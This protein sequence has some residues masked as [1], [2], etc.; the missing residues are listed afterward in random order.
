MPVVIREG[1]LRY[2]FYSNEGLPREPR[3]VHV[4]GRGKDAKVWLEPDVSIA[5]SY[6]FNSAELRRILQT[7]SDRRDLI[8]R[9]WDEHF[10]H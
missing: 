8:L 1:G 10:G 9:A 5:D 3:H 6:G 2:F 4:K 7:V